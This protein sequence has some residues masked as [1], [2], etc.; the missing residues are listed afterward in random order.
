MPN[1]FKLMT[2]E[3]LSF[4]PQ[5]SGTWDGSVNKCFYTLVHRCWITSY[6]CSSKHHNTEISDREELENSISV[7]SSVWNTVELTAVFWMTEN[8][9]AFKSLKLWP[10]NHWFMF[11]RRSVKSEQLMNWSCCSL[12]LVAA[13]I[14]PA[15]C[16]SYIG[17]DS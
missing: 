15:L 6:K 10:Y 8:L 2:G 4:L 12:C 11:K 5:I 9:P 7:Y 1:I 16:L 13:V 3:T 14:H 17:S